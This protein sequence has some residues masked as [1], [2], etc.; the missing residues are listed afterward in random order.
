[1][2]TFSAE[3]ATMVAVP[4]VS[5]APSASVMLIASV[6]PAVVV[7]VPSAVTPSNVY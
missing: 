2:V 1:M 3:D 6:G 7:A 5:T 4:A